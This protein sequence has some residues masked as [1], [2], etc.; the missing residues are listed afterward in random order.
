MFNIIAEAMLIATRLGGSD[1][2]RGLS[3]RRSNDEKEADRLRQKLDVEF[4][5]RGTFTAGPGR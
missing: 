5:R 1:R 4:L 3:G 2:D